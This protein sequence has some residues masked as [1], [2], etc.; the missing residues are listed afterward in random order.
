MGNLYFV[1]PDGRVYDGVPEGVPCIMVHGWRNLE[2]VFEELKEG[3]D[4]RS[5][6]ERMC[7]RCGGFAKNG[8]GDCG[9]GRFEPQL[10]GDVIRLRYYV[11]SF[12]FTP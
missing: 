12:G 8:N 4:F 10:K 11:L 7:V 5:I 1:T 6:A 9:C 2:A 3:T